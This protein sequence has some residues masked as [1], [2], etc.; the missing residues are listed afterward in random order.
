MTNSATI[1]LG[2]IL[3]GDIPDGVTAVAWADTSTVETIEQVTDPGNLSTM[4]GLDYDPATVGQ[5]VYDAIPDGAVAWKFSDPTEP[6]RWLTFDDDTA[7]IRAEDPSLV[8]HF[9]DHSQ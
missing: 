8:A 7:R 1:T 3:D 6:G 5:L 2:Q 4:S 9:A